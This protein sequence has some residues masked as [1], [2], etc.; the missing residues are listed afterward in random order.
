MEE[1]PT[2]FEARSLYE[3]AFIGYEITF[4]VDNIANP[5]QLYLG[6]AECLRLGRKAPSRGC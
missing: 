2:I 3:N 6:G 1:A 5:F 4:K